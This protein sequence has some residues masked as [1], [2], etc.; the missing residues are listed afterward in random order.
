MD[1]LFKR[2][3]LRYHSQGRAGKIEVKPTKP[4]ATQRDLSLAY[5]PGVAEPC[6]EIE[7]NP[8]T[9]YNYTSKS[10]LV[11]VISNGTAVLGLGDIGPLAAK[12][13]MEGKGLLFKI[14]ADLDVFD[15]EVDTKDVEEFIK[16]VKNIAPT[17][18]GI[19]LEDIKA[20][21]CFEIERRLKAELNIPVMH[22]DQHGTA[23]ISAAGLLNA[24]EI[25][26]KNIEEI[27]VVVNGAG[28]A[29]VSCCRLYKKLGVK[30]KN[31]VMLD[32][33]GVIRADREKLSTEK[34]EF[35]THLDIYTLEDA[36]KGADMFLGLS[37]ANVF[38]P[39][40]LLSM[41]KNPIVFALANPNPEINY[42]L[43]METRNDVIMATGR[44]DFPNQ[45]NNVLGFPYIFRGA[46]D[47]RST[48][49]NEEMKVAAVKAI[50][51]LAKEPV[52]EEVNVAYAHGNL[53]FGKKYLVPKPTDPRLLETIAPAVA[54][55]AIESGVARREIVNWKAYLEGL[56]KRLGIGHPLLRKLK[57]QAKKSLKKILL[58]EAD[59]YKML[60]AA[61][62]VM[63][64]KIGIPVLLGDHKRIQKIIEE[65]HL[66]LEGVE[67]INPW[68]ADSNELIEKFARDFYHKRKRSG[69]SLE[70]ARQIMK[71]R[72][73][74]APAALNFGLADGLIGGLNSTY[75][76]T[77]KPAMQ[78][79]G[80]KD[81]DSLV[82]GMY[83][84]LTREGPYFLADTT[85]NK[86][87]DLNQL[88]KI[89]LQT[90]EIVRAY[91]IEPHIALLSYSNF[92]SADG[93]SPINMKKA[94]AYFHKHHPEIFVDGELQAN[95]AL[96][97]ELLSERFPFSKLAGKPVNTLIFPN[98]SSGN[99]AYKLI[100][101]MGD[102]RVIGPLL[103]GLRK[104]VHIL[105]LGS[106]V[107]EIVDMIIVAVN[108]AAK[109]KN[110]DK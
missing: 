98:L 66:E 20:P 109:F 80:K 87:P 13:V 76:E 54:R 58:T 82:M 53:T 79:L 61:E 12:P 21:E 104:P 69:I 74:F 59:Q 97:N 45:I 28:A 81:E 36:A 94:A 6:L 68:S 78:I 107:E 62:I 84:V 67:I 9:V 31:I 75:P 25:I 100:Q 51:N 105:Q 39:E 32:S 23:M 95:F 90:A 11:A 57:A 40:M 17:F 99:I 70:K 42:D 4:H 91:E 93:Y 24:L 89:T 83:I 41:N 73:Y 88:I 48:D 18:G 38:S 64:E 96:N 101:S 49:I 16:T 14:Y 5:S 7:K 52:P 35:A 3:A 108:D 50:A 29:A 15:I 102:S 19:N 27:K 26:D 110:M 103:N 56:R 63:N 8:E 2:D 86:N 72:N 55:A 46:L 10:N 47:V 60:K 30:E 65:N 22:D 85:V 43:A 34:A 71:N 92:G 44:S 33:K 37:V 77:I 1:S 106:S